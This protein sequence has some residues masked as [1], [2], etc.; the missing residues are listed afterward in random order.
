MPLCIDTTQGYSGRYT[1]TVTVHTVEDDLI[2]QKE[3][4]WLNNLEDGSHLKEQMS[5]KAMSSVENA[6][7]RLHPE[8]CVWLSSR[9]KPV[10]S[11]IALF[12]KTKH[13]KH[14][15]R[16]FYFRQFYV[17]KCFAAVILK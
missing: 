2:C 11:L 14:T 5:S 16:F 13:Q 17:I 6:I 4:R 8:M 9:R 10:I 1:D 12:K 3:K 7:N 15:R